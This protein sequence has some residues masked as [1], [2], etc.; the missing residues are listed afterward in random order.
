M[1]PFIPAAIENR[2]MSFVTT[3]PVLIM[4]DLPIVTFGSTDTCSPNQ[5]FSSIKIAPG[6]W[7]YLF[8]KITIFMVS[9]SYYRIRTYSNIIIY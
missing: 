7:L 2:G 4:D 3:L 1:F 6:E 8:A 5:I 9:R